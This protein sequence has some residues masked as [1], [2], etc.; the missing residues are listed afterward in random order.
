MSS[1][2]HAVAHMEHEIVPTRR[3]I[4]ANHSQRPHH[5]APMLQ[6]PHPARLPQGQR[7]MA[8]YQRVLNRKTIMTTAYDDETSVVREGQPNDTELF[9]LT[10][11][12]HRAGMLSPIS[13][14]YLPSP[15]HPAA[16]TISVMSTHTFDSQ[17]ITVEEDA[18]DLRYSTDSFTE[19][20]SDEA[21][22]LTRSGQ[23]EDLIATYPLPPVSRP[24]AKYFALTTYFHLMAF[25]IMANAIALIIM[26]SKLKDPNITAFTYNQA[27]TATAFV[28]AVGVLTRN[29][30]YINGLVHSINFIFPSAPLR[31][32]S[33]ASKF[34]YHQ[35]GIHAGCGISALAWYIAYLILLCTQ[36][37]KDTP[38]G[39]AI[40]ALSAIVGLLLLAI[41]ALSH[42][43]MRNRYHDLWEYNHRWVGYLTF[44]LIWVQEI[45]IVI[46]T[47]IREQ[48][49][50]NRLSTAPSFWAIV[51]ITLCLLHP[52]IYLHRHK[53]TAVRYSASSI[54]VTFS[55][56]KPI[57]SVIGIRLALTP[58]GSAHG[59]ATIPK[60]H[61]ANGFDVLITGLGD[62][63]K[64]F[65]NNP[66][67][68]IWSRGYP[69][70]GVLRMALLF[71]PIVLV[72]TGSG[73]GPVLSFLNVHTPQHPV[74]LVW[75][76]PRA[77]RDYSPEVLE[78]I[79]HA[80][81]LATVVDTKIDG[82][83][84]IVALAWAIKQARGGE[85]F[86]FI[87]RQET[88][89]EFVAAMEARGVPC[90]GAIFDS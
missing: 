61:Q 59:F 38:L 51:F 27:S 75:I 52:W 29:G 89:T 78:A 60:P 32:R 21:F 66:P 43:Y 83:P 55:T 67:S 3:S 26:L 12:Q 46:S 42:S 37:T 14:L 82:R 5:L 90:L 76:T 48:A 68:H 63:T 40:V 47:G 53:I 17:K 16:L 36:F 58:F 74:R 30:L 50:G 71:K 33:H 19:E 13:L 35:G 11:S 6:H 7:T 79:F 85:A 2:A 70:H 22:S 9:T 64:N 39:K 23:F 34:A 69:T 20:K 77:R 72:A 65:V 10:S 15:V 56:K 44:S 45:L 57:P 31:I 86:G 18:L 8:D 81:P 88:T 49:V 25:V 1:P 87:G 24:L 28:L 62:W 80:D 84:D 73:I 4:A 54:Q 41:C